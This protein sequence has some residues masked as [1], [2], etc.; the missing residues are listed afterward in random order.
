VTGVQTCALPIFIHRP[1][2]TTLLALGATLAGALAYFQLP[3]SPLPQVD[4]PT[5]SVSAALPGASP[6]TMAA[7][8][9][10]P[11]ERA[12]GQI[13]GVTEMTSSSTLGSTRV[14]LQFDLSRDIN[15]AARDVQAA[16]QAAR[17][18]LP[19]GLPN[20]PTWKKVNPADSPI[21]ILSLTSASLSRA[22]VYDAASTVLAQRLAQVTGIGEVRIGGGSAPA[23]RVNVNPTALS[24]AGLSLENVRTVLN[25]AHAYRPLGAVEDGERRWQ[26]GASDQLTGAAGFGALI[27]RYRNGAAVRLADVGAVTDSVQD[28]RHFGAIHRDGQEKPAVL[29]ILYRQPGANIIET[30]DSVRELLPAL[31]A[32]IPVAIELQPVMDRTA[33]IRASLREV[34]RT[35]AIAVGLVILVVFVF[36]RRV[37][38]A[39]IPSVA[40][41]VSLIATYAVM[42][43][44]GYSLDNLSLMALTVATGFVVDDA[45][46]VIENIMRHLEGGMEPFQAALA[47]VREIGFT[48]VTISVSLVAV[49]IPILF[50]GGIL[51]RL[52]REFAVTLSAA[53]LVSMVVS[54]TLTPMLAAHWLKG[55]EARKRRSL[56]PGPSP[57]G[58]RGLEPSPSGGGQGEGEIGRASCR[59][60]V[61]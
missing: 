5:V 34:E 29:L 43:L 35:L 20:L 54:L 38:A 41:P 28:I 42:Y 44:C 36:L 57:E 9:A 13:A 49:F 32:S 23:V 22:Q 50:M 27:L 40:V 12:L 48:V 6:E 15:G 45:I 39:L 56:I 4:F 31:R 55:R 51:G 30:V 61:S 18:L 37:R 52:F 59:E 17:P 8:V 19:T 53:V 24:H 3:V 58:G 1:V 25:S 47:G 60:R 7:T 16:I 46:V 26:V 33:T 11:L 10:T 21:M 14:T 2:A